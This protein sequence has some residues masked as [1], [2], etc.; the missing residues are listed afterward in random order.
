[1]TSAVLVEDHSGMKLDKVRQRN[2][3][4]RPV[5]VRSN[6]AKL[7]SSKLGMATSWC[8]SVAVAFRFDDGVAVTVPQALVSSPSSLP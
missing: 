3:P 6:V 4:L 8:V 2:E 7:G 1:M 5:M